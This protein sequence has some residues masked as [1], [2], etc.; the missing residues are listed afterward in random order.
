M[1]NSAKLLRYFC[2]CALSVFL[3]VVAGANR[4]AAQVETATVSGTATD[5]SGAALV[6]AAV[7]A[8][9]VGRNITQSTIT[10]A[11]GRYRVHDLPVGEYE[12]Q[13]SLSGFQ[14]VV[15]KGITLT[16]GANL[17]VDFSLPVG[18]VSQ[19]VS[20]EGEV[21]RVETQTA[22][23][24]SLVTSQQM[25]QLPLNG[26]NFAQLLS[27]APGVQTI[28]QAYI[29]GGGGGGISSG[30]YGPS[31]TYSV[32]GSR[33]VGQVFLLDNQDLQGYWEK[34][35]GASI[36]GN[37]LGVDGIQ[38]FQLLTNTYSAQFGGTGAAMNAVSK[39]GTNGFHGSAY[40][41]LRNSA[42]DARDYFD[43]AKIPP[44]RRN[45]FGGD[46]GGPVKK[47]KV[48]FFVNY[49]GL[50]STLGIT[51]N[52]NVPDRD[53]V[54]AGTYSASEVPYVTGF[55]PC[56]TVPGQLPPSL[57]GTCN[58]G[59]RLPVAINPKVLPYLNQPSASF[60]NPNTYP[61]PAAGAL[62]Q[63]VGAG[64]FKGYPSGNQ[65]VTQIGSQPTSENYILGRLDYT[66]S[67]KD[68]VFGRYIS[69][70]AFLRLP[71]PFS[72]LPNWPAGFHG[73][74]Q[75]FTVE[76]KHIISATSINEIRFSFSRT[77][78]RSDQTFLADP[79]TDPLQF[80]LGAL[81][82]GQ[83][84]YNPGDR[85]DGNLIVAGGTS[86]I[87]PGATARWH[88][89]ENKFVGGDDIFWSQG[90]HSLKV[91]L[92]VTRIQDSIA[93]GREGGIFIF[94][95]LPAFLSATP[96]QFQG[97]VNP[98]PGFTRT[99][100]S[101]ATEY[102]PYIQDD[103]KV[104]PNLTINLGLR[105]DFETNPVCVAEPCNAI[106]D[107]LS[108]PGFT[109]VRHV[110]RSNPD[111][112]N[113]DPRIGVAWDPFSDHKTSIRAGFGIFHEPIAARTYLNSYSQN[114]PSQTVVL[115]GPPAA[116]L[117]P[118][119]ADCGPAGSP[120][121]NPPFGTIYQIDYRSNVAP[122]QMQYNLT[123]QRDMGHGMVASLGYVG[124]QGVHLYSQRNLNTPAL[125]D[126][127]GNPAPDNCTTCFFK[128][129]VPNSNFL[130]LDATA[131]TSHSTYN[132][133]VAS[134]AR[135]LNKNL[136]G[137]VSYTYS[138]CIDDGS[139]SSGLEQA[140][141]EVLDAHF[142]RFDR[143]PCIFNITH[144]LRVNGIYNLPFRGNR[145]V[146]GWQVGEILS[147]AT[148]FPV[149]VV[150]GLLPQVANTG[151]ITAD[152][153]NFVAGCHRYDVQGKPSGPFV[154]WFDPSC[155]AP[156]TF[157]TL[158]NVKRNSLVGPGLLDLDFSIIKQ[159]RITEKLNS[160]FRAEF[161]NIINHTNLGQ[162]SGSVFAGPGGAAAG[163][164]F[165][166]GTAG[167]IST[168]STTSR[169]IQFALK[170]IF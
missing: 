149:N 94:S 43:G 105:Y 126:A 15:H 23:V 40:E 143:G 157:G 8:R 50:R 65:L 167:L 137:Q 86:N 53:S 98:H 146:S 4:L 78:E 118:R 123:V 48:F 45:Q 56:N 5:S 124:A 39:S 166:G 132:G 148:G 44:F 75:F 138:R 82:N 145:L 109:Q 83:P 69:D 17:V 11:A 130:G 129:P 121:L 74:D 85:E 92:S 46:V 101:R 161:F 29:T 42:L 32:A 61:L 87:G 158:G 95:S 10:D 90:A 55:V 96:I 133:L 13:A 79:A 14:T 21:S 120:C 160:E 102:F 73:G 63:T 116:P 91:G 163:G 122:Y 170:L 7:Q 97:E 34:G 103:W 81:F 1:A 80:Y 41:Y 140:S 107:P 128:G 115:A 168:A 104:R 54:G 159:T 62:E 153:P 144:A 125:V 51:G 134:L 19:T 165:I 150:N 110:V 84:A 141:A 139:A 127:L 37:S 59:D 12:V 88:L 2:I 35:A 30:F 70:T 112:F 117:F 156:Q 64:P 155:F 58:P 142:Q 108:S 38:E 136:Q 152:R 36:T 113:F 77:N 27:L 16:V 151:G 47:D 52:Q 6:G 33:P 22:A 99:R 162:P 66:L 89:I 76:E 57:G 111:A 114:P 9:N 119:P 24:S 31:D 147:V 100:Y 28:K 93:V 154:Q 164:S 18:Q 3:F 68:S 72:N 169:Q 60:P 49:E 71:M 25:S 20:V 67:S 131:P 135:Q 106:L 26:R